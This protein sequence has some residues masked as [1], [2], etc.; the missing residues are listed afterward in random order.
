MLQSLRKE[1]T[2]GSKRKSEGDAEEPAIKKRPAAKDS[3]QKKP[4][5]GP[6]SVDTKKQVTWA[7]AD[8]E[9]PEVLPSPC[10]ESPKLPKHEPP[11]TTVT[12]AKTKLLFCQKLKL[13]TSEGLG[14]HGK[15][16]TRAT[17]RA[18]TRQHVVA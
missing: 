3:M 10:P 6:T 12:F 1:S 15:R 5:D 2:T 11:K 17:T 9:C 8:S 14:N 13:R 16:T 18:N 4:A 7:T